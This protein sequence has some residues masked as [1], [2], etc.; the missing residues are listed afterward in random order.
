MGM[1]PNMMMPGFNMNT[2]MENPNYPSGNFDMKNNKG[3][4]GSEDPNQNYFGHNFY[5][6]P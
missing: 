2:Q 6:K 3:S 4:T 1:N 5:S